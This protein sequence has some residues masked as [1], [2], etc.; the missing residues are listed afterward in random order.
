MI[1]L[2][3]SKLLK[4]FSRNLK[5]LIT[6]FREQILAF[7]KIQHTVYFIAFIFPFVS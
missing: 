3:F 1:P 2:K 4:I 6:L 7:L 5:H